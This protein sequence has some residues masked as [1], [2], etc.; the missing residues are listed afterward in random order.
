MKIITVPNVPPGP[1]MVPNQNS[2]T[3]KVNSFLNRRTFI[4]S[5]LHNL[6]YQLNIFKKL[7]D[8][9]YSKLNIFEYSNLFVFVPF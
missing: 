9:F 1:K 4:D 6:K 2:T 5:D 8:I 3:D 7:L